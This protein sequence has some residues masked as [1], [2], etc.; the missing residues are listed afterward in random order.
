MTCLI[1]FMGITATVLVV[2]CVCLAAVAL[3]AFIMLRL[4]TVTIRRNRMYSPSYCNDE[5]GMLWITRRW[6]IASGYRAWMWS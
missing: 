5:R 6:V 2:L 4:S 3:I 1:A